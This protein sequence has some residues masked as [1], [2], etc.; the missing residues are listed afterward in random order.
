MI[1]ELTAGKVATPAIRFAKSI[2]LKHFRNSRR[3]KIWAAL[4]S[5]KGFVS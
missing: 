1:G 3:E 5:G 2:A 4:A